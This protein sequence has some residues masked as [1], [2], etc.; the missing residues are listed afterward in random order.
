MFAALE[1]AKKFAP[2]A[3]I[4]QIGPMKDLVTVAEFTVKY[5][6]SAKEMGCL[7]LPLN[8]R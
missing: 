6:V 3:P 2:A 4:N 8:F 1:K 7:F 5:F